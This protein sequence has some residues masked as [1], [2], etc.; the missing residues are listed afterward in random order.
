VI[1]DHRAPDAPPVDSLAEAVVLHHLLLNHDLIDSADL[2]GLLVFPEHRWCWHAMRTV[3]QRS[4]TLTFGAFYLAWLDELERCHPDQGFA[5][6][7]L[8]QIGDTELARGWAEYERDTRDE[9]CRR[10]HHHGFVWWLTRLRTI[11]DARRALSALQ[12][13]SECAWREDMDGARYALAAIPLPADRVVGVD[14][15][16][17]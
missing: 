17:P 12:A 11:S 8:L 16:E 7:A 6:A 3:H 9:R 14:P 15:L 5:L 10:D 4:P 1:G 13:A 2:N